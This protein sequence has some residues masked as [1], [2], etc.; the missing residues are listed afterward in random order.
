MNLC[1]KKSMQGGLDIWLWIVKF[2]ILLSTHPQEFS[3]WDVIS[4]DDLL[5]I[6]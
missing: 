3:Q 2:S 4:S 1:I 6:E 5:Y